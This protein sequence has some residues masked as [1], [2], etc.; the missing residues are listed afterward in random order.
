M[1]VEETGYYA[2]S[3]D[4]S[5]DTFGDIYEDDF[6]PMNP[7][8]NLLSQDYRSCS[9]E[10]FKFIVY[11]HTGTKYILVVTTSSPNITGNFSILTSGSTNITLNP[12]THV[13]TNC[14]IGQKCQFY[15]KSIG[16]I[17]DDILRDEIRSNMTL[18]D[19][20]ILVKS[21]AVLTMIMFVGGLINSILSIITFQSK[22][23]RQVGCGIYLLAS[24][25]TSFLTISMLAVKFW[26]VVVTQMNLSIRVSV[27]RDGCVSIEPFLKLC[28]YV[29]AW[30]NACVA[31][32]RAILVLKGIK[33]NKQNS[34]RIARWI[35]LILPFSCLA[36][37][38]CLAASF[39][40]S[41]STCE[42]F[43]NVSNLTE[44][45]LPDADITT[46]IVQDKTR[47]P[48]V[49]EPEAT[50]IQTSTAS[51]STISACINM[52]TPAGRAPTIG[53]D[54]E[55]NINDRF[56]IYNGTDGNK[57]TYALGRTSCRKCLNLTSSLN[58]SVYI[59]ATPYI[60]LRNI[61]FSVEAWIKPTIVTDGI[62][63][64]ILAQCGSLYGYSCMRTSIG[65]LGSMS[66]LF[67]SDTQ[68]GLHNV[69]INV[70]SHLAYVYNKTAGTM[71][72]YLN[73]TLDT[74]GGSHGPYYG[75][76]TFFQ[77]GNIDMIGSIYYDGCIDDIFFYP[78]ARTA[79]EIA[80]TFALG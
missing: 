2:L 30:L 78:F 58:Q 74:S 17:L 45:M 63:H 39:H 54:F 26:F 28:F 55:G 46:M 29:D 56:L 59:N 11:L 76:P 44:N 32:E 35:I 8:E 41:T 65:N 51:L 6:N 19:Q 3:S 43:A 67:R 73:G 68:T 10:D 60:D 52:T 21:N 62:E 23:L 40:K 24:S 12:Y 50:T 61:S 57:S 16:I 71:S 36:Q 72:L 66:F 37:T 1:Y 31:V 53:W 69:S 9:Y 42:L 25:I 33:F 70:W 22:D 7:F 15:K 48:Q 14:F 27:L 5:M 20:T 75:S 79:S 38:Q 80:A 49:F 47:I 64:V 77:F 34:Q 4:S 13:L 18:S